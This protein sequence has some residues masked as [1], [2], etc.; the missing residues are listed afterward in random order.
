MVGA[1]E[2]VIPGL[3]NNI[4]YY[5]KN[6]KKLEQAIKELYDTEQYL[7]A[8]KRGI[9]PVARIK[10]MVEFSKEIFLSGR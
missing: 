8:T 10:K 5:L 7:A 1:Y 2:A 3:T 4:E 9:R 6:K